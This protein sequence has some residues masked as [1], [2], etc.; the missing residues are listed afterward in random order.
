MKN[1]TKDITIEELAKKIAENPNVRC[2]IF[3]GCGEYVNYCRNICPASTYNEDI[4]KRKVCPAYIRYGYF[5]QEARNMWAEEYLK[6]EYLEKL[7]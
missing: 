3:F 5:S 1:N 7:K 4:P 2:Y 6:L